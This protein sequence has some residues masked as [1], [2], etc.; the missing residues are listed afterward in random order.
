MAVIIQG[1]M[2]RSKLAFDLLTQ[3]ALEHKADL[4][5]ISEQYCGM[6]GRNWYPDTTGTAAIWVKNPSMF[7]VTE[8]GKGDGYVWVRSEN[9]TY[10]SVYLSPNE[11][12]DEFCRKL[13]GLED[14]TREI[15]GEVIVA[16]DFN[17]KAMEWGMS[18]TCNRGVRVVEMAARLDLTIL[19]TGTVSTFRRS[20]CCGTIIDITLASAGVSAVIH[21]WHVLEDFTGS[22]HQYAKYWVGS[23]SDGRRNHAGSI[24]IRGWNV[25]KLSRSAVLESLNR[26]GVL[27]DEA[28]RLQNTTRKQAENLVEQTMCLIKRTCDN[29]MPR[30]SRLR[31]S[32]QNYWWN[33]EIADLRREALAMRRKAQRK[34][35]RADAGAAVDNFRVAK[36]AL[37]KAIKSSKRQGWVSLLDEV[38]KDVWGR[39]YKIVTRCLGLRAPEPPRDPVIMD[40]IVGALFP[41]HPERICTPISVVESEVQLLSEDE[42]RRVVSSLGNRKA[43]GPDGIPVEILKLIANEYPLIFLNMYNACLLAGIFPKRWKMQRLVLLDKGKGPPINSS[44][45]RPLC[46]LDNAGKIFEK[47][48]RSR[49]RIAIEESGGLSK[50]QHGFRTNRSTIGAI[51]EVISVTQRAW[52]GN[53]RSRNSCVLV[54]L[55]VKNAFNSARW[56]DILDALEHRFMVPAYLRRVISDY[57]D[58]RKLLYDT[59]EGQQS[60]KVTSGIAQ[61]SALGPDL[62]NVVYNGVLE[63]VLPEWAKLI[64]FAD[65]LAAMILARDTEQAQQ[66]VAHVTYLVNNWLIDHGL[67]LATNKTE[68]VVLTRQRHYEDTV[69]FDIIG[70]PIVAAKAVRYLGEHVDQKLTHWPQIQKAADKAST[71]VANLSRLMPSIRGPRA[72]KRRVLMSVAHSILL[73]GAEIWADA[74]DVKKYRMRIASVQRRCALRIA[75]AYRTVSE[76]AIMVVAGVIPIFLLAKERKRVYERKQLEEDRSIVRSEE[77]DRILAEWQQCWITDSRGRWTARLIGEVSPWFGRNHGEINFHL[78]QFL[79][80]HGHFNAYLHRRNRKENENCDYCPTEVDSVEHTFYDCGRWAINKHEL[81]IVLGEEITPENTVSVM[82]SSKEAWDAVSLYVECVLRQKKKEE[83]ERMGSE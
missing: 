19:N 70:E 38:D 1:N 13:D 8:M 55:D 47:L 49:L 34:R 28:A 5:I 45:F 58:D 12:I 66:R 18:W 57:L 11:G 37:T 21:G 52:Q 78:T 33:N 80:G 14:G 43:P 20:G 32:E 61:G 39:G 46:M 68:V 56:V 59:T 17:A 27:I 48:L 64:G 60:C 54:T 82:L 2:G 41:V 71:T 35:G 76:P 69:R 15:D 26:A 25:A 24:K 79:S 40:V 29:S 81:E 44:S 62:W 75:S 9:T 51:R 53:H 7:P 72:S 74:L 16:G 31:Q 83:Q 50:K 6:G 3:L 73:Y 63:I 4:L 10:V 30:R 65:D 67:S 36:K 42:L 22:D 23:N 77:R